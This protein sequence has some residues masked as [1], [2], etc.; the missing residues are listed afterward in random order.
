MSIIYDGKVF[1]NIQEQVKK[2]MEDIKELKN[3]G[4]V[5]VIECSKAYE[6]SSQY[7]TEKEIE[8]LV[9][10]FNI[11]I[12]GGS[13][14]IRTGIVI[15]Q[16]RPI[17][18]YERDIHFQQIRDSDTNLNYRELYVEKAE[19]RFDLEVQK[20]KI[21]FSNYKLGDYFERNAVKWLANLYHHNIYL[22]CPGDGGENSN[23][24]A[25]ISVIDNN[26]TPFTLETLHD[27][28][29]EV[30][31]DDTQYPTMY[32][33]YYPCNGVDTSDEQVLWG[34]SAWEDQVTHQKQLTFY[35]GNETSVDME[36]IEELEFFDKVTSVAR[37]RN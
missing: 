10:K 24:R 36:N 2:N 20:Y 32:S 25:V 23:I 28:I 31:A 27:Y 9:N 8:L 12:Y 15:S 5:G 18:S 34:V 33:P 35:K 1:R 26:S 6:I 13:T 21:T 19:I 29:K 30:T 14:Y 22:I 37:I 11:I 16:N 3:S 17:I 4:E 7:L